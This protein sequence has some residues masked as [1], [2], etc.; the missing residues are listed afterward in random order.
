MANTISSVSTTPGT[1]TTTATRSAATAG[2]G[3]SILTGLGVGGSLNL[4]SLLNGLMQVESIPLTQLQSS[5]SGV[6]TEISA[7]G[8]LSS[9]L[10]TFQASLVN[11]TSRSIS[12]SSRARYRTRLC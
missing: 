12:S 6:Q 3:S 7:Y 11:L 1:T 8:K 4:N 5:I 10:A 2:L 9:A